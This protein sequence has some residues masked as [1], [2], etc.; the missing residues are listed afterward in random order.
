MS[1]SAQ[2]QVSVRYFAAARA[3]AGVEQEEVTLDGQLSS[4][5]TREQFIELLTSHHPEV[6]AGE[7]PLSRVL[8]QCSFLVDG[9]AL[10]DGTVVAGN[11]VDVLPPF[12]GG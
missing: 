10:T 4:G 8:P 12:A 5:A 9:V 3:A 1:A 6:P 7:P 11:R 2:S